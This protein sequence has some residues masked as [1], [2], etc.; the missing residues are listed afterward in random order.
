MF[1]TMWNRWTTTHRFQQKTSRCL[2][3]CGFEEGDRIEH[4]CRCPIVKDICR[5]R[6]NISAD[7]FANL[8]FIYSDIPSHSHAQHLVHGR[9]PELRSLQGGQQHPTQVQWNALQGRGWR[10]RT[11]PSSSGRSHGPSVCYQV[12]AGAVEC[13]FCIGRAPS[14]TDRCIHRTVQAI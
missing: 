13:Y 1:S 8:Q 3:G 6:L 7:M 9:A 2:L 12:T 10:R 14:C 4:Y 5:K 11:R